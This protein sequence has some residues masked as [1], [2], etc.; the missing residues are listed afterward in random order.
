M[1][2]MI[3]LSLLTGTLAF[4]SEQVQIAGQ[5]PLFHDA[6]PSESIALDD[7]AI[8]SNVA[9]HSNKTQTWQSLE[10]SRT[11]ASQIRDF[12][13]TFR[14]ECF[15]NEN[16][17][18]PFCVF[19]DQ[20]FASGRGIFIVG[21]ETLAYSMLE[22]DAFRRPEVLDRMNKY[23]NPS[24]EQHEFPGKGRGLVA[25]KTLHRGDQIFASTPLLITDPD[26]YQLST[27]ERL[28]LLYRGVETLPPASQASFWELMGHYDGDPVDDRINTNNF[29]LSI[30][31]I[32]HSGLFPEIAMMNH[33][34]RPNAAYFWDARTMTHYVHALRD[35]LPGEEITITYIDNEQP[36]AKRMKKLERNWGFRCSCSSCT[37]HP[38][39]T[40]ESD[41]RLHQIAALLDMLN[42]WTPASS[43]TPEAVELLVTLY[44]QERLHANLA[45]AYKHAAEVYSSFGRKFEA[46]RYARLS[47]ELSML[48]KGFADEDVREMRNMSKN[49][50]MSWSWNKRVGL[51]GKSGCGCARKH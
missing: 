25:N 28:A 24:F 4:A 29:E 8:I 21:T 14:P 3:R 33:D 31:G 40:A 15:S 42:D 18:E 43:A 41:S 48:D 47:T 6:C 51:S 49:P 38:A 37:A 19:S 32:S 22:K 30:N 44:E 27:S 1:K 45:T 12:P 36:R 35:I 2:S 17:T 9:F 39:L 34:C 7:N 23:D 13:W 11:S 46:I 26:I 50:E 5:Q 16:T 10:E 20:T